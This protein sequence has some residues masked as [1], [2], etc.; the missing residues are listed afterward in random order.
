MQQLEKGLSS[1][2]DSEKAKNAAM[3]MAYSTGGNV[4][5]M[6]QVFTT[7]AYSIAFSQTGL[8]KSLAGSKDTKVEIS[9][10][11]IKISDGKRKLKVGLERS[12]KNTRTVCKT[13]EES[14]KKEG[15]FYKPKKKEGASTEE[16]LEHILRGQINLLETLLNQTSGNL[17]P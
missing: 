6:S 17:L 1:E 10:F 7:D 16:A 5:D 8:L 3:L 11:T 13:D 15:K 12:G 9:G 2:Q 4:R 14:M